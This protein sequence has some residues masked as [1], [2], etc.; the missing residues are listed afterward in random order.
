MVVF[1]GFPGCHLEFIFLI[2]TLNPTHQFRLP[3]QGAVSRVPYLLHDSPR[4]AALVPGLRFVHDLGLEH[5]GLP[6]SYFFP[7]QVAHSRGEF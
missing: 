6:G 3:G 1:P 7:Q 5:H 2:K 4:Y